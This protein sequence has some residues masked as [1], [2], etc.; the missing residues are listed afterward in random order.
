MSK[1]IL[2][3]ILDPYELS[4]LFQPIF[5]IQGGARRVHSVEALIRG[6]RGTH[7]ERA[8][9]LFDY[10]RRKKAEAAVD[11]SCLTAICDAAKG[12]PAGVRI[13]VNVHA[14]TLGHSSNFVDFFR[15]KTQKMSLAP[16]WFTMEIVEYAPTCNIPELTSN[17]AKLRNWGVRI[18]LD[19]VGLGQSNYRMM[20]DCRPEYFKLDAYFVHDLATDTN[21]RAVVRSLVALAKTLESSVVA[22]G[23][24]ASDD[25]LQLET[26]GV[27]F[28]QA[29][30]L[31]PAISLKKLLAT[32]YLD[33]LA[34]DTH[35]RPETKKPSLSSFDSQHALLGLAAGESFYT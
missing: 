9:I 31:C 7:F 25:L 8:D 14:A 20:L 34:F 13:N 22:E 29:N 1:P 5:Q 11:Q 21:R 12:L 2:E 10:V 27:E 3:R 18:A 4:V 23:V 6:P 30:L 19:D 28:A 24:A 26:I 16:E 17:L 33:D 15:R 32:S 35:A